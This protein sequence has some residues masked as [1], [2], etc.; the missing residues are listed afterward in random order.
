MNENLDKILI[1]QEQ[2]EEIVSNVA[3][4]IN[5]DYNGEEVFLIVILKG[6]II[7]AADLMRKLNMPVTIDFM[8][9]SSYGS[10]TV[11]GKEINVI[12]DLKTDIK[13]KNVIIVEDIVDSGNTL[14]HLEKILSQRNPKSLRLC[15][16]LDKP[17]RRETEVQPEYVGTEIP[18]EFVVGYGLDYDE[19]FRDLPY[20]GILSRSVYEN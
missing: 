15:T 19:K 11:S 8:K 2:L 17:E 12:L 5:K 16:L 14:Y 1:S 20:I 6:S 9:V 3:E 13:D 7:F 18:D 4:K 10:G